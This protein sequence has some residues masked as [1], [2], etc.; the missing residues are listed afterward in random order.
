M[1]IPVVDEH[2][3]LIGVVNTH[4]LIDEILYPIW[5]RKNK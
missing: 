1:S 4:D 5:K 3:V 2:E